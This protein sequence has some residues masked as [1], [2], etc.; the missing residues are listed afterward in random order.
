MTHHF[1]CKPVGVVSYVYTIPLAHT[2]TRNGVRYEMV[3]GAP[4]CDHTYGRIR[5]TA[6]KRL[7]AWDGLAASEITLSLQLGSGLL[8][9]A[10]SKMARAVR[11]AIPTAF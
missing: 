5:A 1:E 2:Y 8:G 3:T 4:L 7:L 6:Q 9:T 11:N 10:D